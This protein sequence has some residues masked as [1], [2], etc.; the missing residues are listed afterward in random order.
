MKYTVVW[1]NGVSRRTAPTTSNS[2]TTLTP[3]A[4]GTITDVVQDNI[5]DQTDPT[6]NDKRWVKFADGYY[7]ASNY[8][9]GAG[10]KVRMEKVVETPPPA[11]LPVIEVGYDAAKVKV[12]LLPK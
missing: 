12:I 9:D 3:Y 7:G 4:F 2:A 10:P 1:S 11:E 6:N 5:P 8:P